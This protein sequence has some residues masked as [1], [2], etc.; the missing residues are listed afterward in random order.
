MAKI[1]NFEDVRQSY[2]RA[3][4]KTARFGIA[5][6]ELLTGVF[7]CVFGSFFGGM[8][9]LVGLLPVLEGTA[10][11]EGK[12]WI[13]VLVVSV[14][15]L[16]GFGIAVF[17]LS[18]V[19]RIM[20]L[21][22]N[23]PPVNSVPAEAS[24]DAGL[25]RPVFKDAFGKMA[26][27]VETVKAYRR[28]DVVTPDSAV[29]DQKFTWKT[30]LF[31]FVFGSV[32]LAVGLGVSGFGIVSY[33]KNQRAAENWVAVPC[34]IV[35]AEIEEHR[36]GRNSSRS[37]SAEVTFRYSYVGK[38][39]SGDKESLVSELSG[40]Y[41]EAAREL[42]VLRK[43]K[44][45]WIDPENP[46]DSVL[47]KP[48]STF[49]FEKI[50]PIVFGIPFAVAGAFVAGLALFGGRSREKRESVRGEIFPEKES[51]AQTILFSVFWNS[52]LSVFICV[53]LSDPGWFLGIA[54][55]PFAILG[56]ILALCAINAVR[57]KLGGFNYSITLNPGTETL[58]SGV[59]VRVYWKLRRGS[60]EKL[61][62]LSLN[63]V[64][65]RREADMQVN[66]GTVLRVVERTTL[67]VSGA[68][69]DFRS[70]AW[71][72]I[73]P[74]DHPTS[75]RFFAFELELECKSSVYGKITLR[76]PVKLKSHE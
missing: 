31:M 14:F 26:K 53:F 1:K 4:S 42:K 29:S 28:G 73:P 75:R 6:G 12:D 46:I 34:E 66:G 32:F 17:G 61:A 54:L 22:K 71:D 63:F 47:K 45:C 25:P 44:S 21:I 19:I 48:E 5:A 67:C 70:G 37:Y 49:S 33:F 9:L 43:Y 50:I 72:F 18:R 41:R 59:P 7:T 36:G 60:P 52:I 56:A 3:R 64:E 24:C 57:K 35:S 30:R 68:R 15:V 23:A 10:D 76:F 65:M 69:S 39:F 2:L 40:D 13:S 62:G 38:M 55:I 16:V 11:P 8:P 20:L 27:A 51:I 58:V 74:K